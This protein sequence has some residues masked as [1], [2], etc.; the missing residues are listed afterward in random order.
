MWLKYQIL[1]NPF[2]EARTSIGYRPI[3]ITVDAICR[4]S[5]SSGRTVS[6]FK[7]NTKQTKVSKIS[8]WYF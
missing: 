2:N 5:A 7:V 8:I 1:A 3:G 6:R 4:R